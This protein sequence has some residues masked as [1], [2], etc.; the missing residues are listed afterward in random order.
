MEESSKK[1]EKTAQSGAT[2]F[3]LVFSIVM[4]IWARRVACMIQMRLAYK[5]LVGGVWNV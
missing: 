2:W 5:I 3:V 4:M 1:L